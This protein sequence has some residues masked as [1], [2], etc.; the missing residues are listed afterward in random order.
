MPPS[1]QVFRFGQEGAGKTP[2]GEVA[3]D[4]P[5]ARRIQNESKDFLYDFKIH[6]SEHSLEVQVPFIQIVAKDS[7]IVPILISDMKY[8]KP[9]AKA[10]YK[11]IRGRSALVIASTDLSHYH[12]DD[13]AREIDQKTQN[14]FQKLSPDNFREAY[15]KGEIKLCGAAAVLTLLELNQLSGQGEFTNLN[16]ANSGD[17]MQDKS[18]VVGYNASVIST[19]DKIPVEKGQILMTLARDTLLAYLKNQQTPSFLI[20]DPILMQNRAVFVTL[21]DKS[22]NLRGRIGRFEA[23][24]P[25][26]LAVQH[27]TIEAATKD[28]RFSPVILNDFSNLSIEISVLDVPVDIKSANE[29]V[30][31][32]HGVIV[33][34]GRRRGIFLPEV[35]KDFRTKD[36]FLSELCFQ[37]AD[38]PRN[39]WQNPLTQFRVFTTQTIQ[40]KK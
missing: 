4:E 40:E 3:I 2:L 1:L 8:A 10:L 37:K 6:L 39:C 11:H 34:Q 5:L 32:T 25:L 31:G 22:G 23:E 33:T 28:A 21:R 19:S 36:D 20:D 35:A 18:S 38:L 15:E 13:T 9:L 17:Q 29:I 26:Y 24:E 7:K 30:Y 16:Y 27:M 12:P 14:V